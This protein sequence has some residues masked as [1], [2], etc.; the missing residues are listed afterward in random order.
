MF[1]AHT[2]VSTQR[3]WFLFLF[4]FV[5]HTYVPCALRFGFL[6]AALCLAIF[7]LVNYLGSRIAACIARLSESGIISTIM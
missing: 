3:D 6:E 7:N 1:Y 5:L 4:C 2:K